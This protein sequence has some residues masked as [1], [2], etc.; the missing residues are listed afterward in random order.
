MSKKLLLT[1]LV[2]A[3]VVAAAFGLRASLERIG[4]ADVTTAIP[5]PDLDG[6]EPR[7]DQTIRDAREWVYRFPN[8]A[9]HWS[10]L[11]MVLHVHGFADDAI[12][13]YR[14]S[15][16]LSPEDFRWPYYEGI[17]A[18][19]AGVREGRRSFRGLRSPVPAARQSLVRW[20]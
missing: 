7:V 12:P 2:I 18:G 16:E 14:Q 11:A 5:D 8:S 15:A 3:A 1:V 4:P 10:R 17:A 9:E 19:E 6:V 13:A 20:G